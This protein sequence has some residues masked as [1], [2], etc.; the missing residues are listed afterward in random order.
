[1]SGKIK[2]P[3]YSQR[4][5]YD[6]GIEY[7]NFSSNLV[8]NQTIST[9]NAATFTSGNFNITTNID[10][11]ISKFFNLKKYSKYSNLNDLNL[12]VEGIEVNKFKFNL[13]LDKKKLKNY[14]YFGSLKEFLRVSLEKIIIN[15]PAGLKI[16][17]FDYNNP[18]LDYNTY[19]SKS[20]DEVLDSTTF[21]VLKKSIVNPYRVKINPLNT[22][23]TSYNDENPLR[24]LT[25][26]YLNYSIVIGDVYYDLI[27]LT[28]SNDLLILTVKGNPFKNIN[29]KTPYFLRP[30]KTEFEKFFN[31][32]NVF[33]GYLL[34]R[35]ITPI[36][37]AKFDVEVIN[38]SGYNILTEKIVTWPITDG[39]N[40]DYNTEEYLEYV[41]ELIVIAETNDSIKSDLMTRFL[42]SDSILEFDTLPVE[43]NGSEVS[44]G[45]KVNC[46]LKIYGRNF[47]E[48]K[49]YIDGISLAHIVT[50]DASDNTPNEVLKNLA[51]IMGWDVLSPGKDNFLSELLP[52]EN[53]FDGLN[54][55]LN[56]IEV[57]NELWRRLI[58]NTPWLWKSKGTRK[59]LEFIFKFLGI[60]DG[61]LVFNEHIYKFEKS[62][63]T[64]LIQK[65]IDNLENS[66]VFRVDELNID[67]NGFPKINPDNE[68]MY[69]QKAGLWFR[70][71]GGV[72][73]NLD[74]SSGNNPH[75]GVYDGGQEFVNQFKNLIPDFKPTTII[76]NEYINNT[77]KLFVNN[78]FGD[79]NIIEGVDVSI[80]NS[81]WLDISGNLNV[82]TSVVEKTPSIVEINDC[83]CVY[84]GF[85]G[86][87]TIKLKKKELVNE[88]LY[89]SYEFQ[90]NGLIMFNFPNNSNSLNISPECC[91][92]L[93]FSSEL[94][95][96]NFYVCRWKVIVIDNCSLYTIKDSNGAYILFTKDGVEI[97]NVPS[98][99]CCPIGSTAEVYG[100]RFKCLKNETP[101]CQPVTNIIATITE[102]C[103]PVTNIV[104]SITDDYVPPV[105]PTCAPVTNITSSI[106][107]DYVPP[108]SSN[109][110]CYGLSFTGNSYSDVCLGNPITTTTE[111]LTITL[112]D[113]NGNPVI[114]TENYTFIV[115]FNEKTCLYPESQI[116][117]EYTVLSGN[118]SVM[119]TYRTNTYVDCGQGNCEPEYT[120]YVGIASKPT[121]L[122]NIV[123]CAPTV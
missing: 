55:G 49:K 118:S 115:S 66:T 36:Y 109:I 110:N 106:V 82:M 35:S 119:G 51:T 23:I 43:I 100:N 25:K 7:R 57:E 20:Y 113:V 104:S 4:V 60:P 30:N 56:K 83:G 107:D 41:K 33:E 11:K 37:T 117:R 65:T 52:E 48:V 64:I 105:E 29:D 88:C 14:S 77:D 54:K 73:S 39:Y 79:Y 93:G 6:N 95:E 40:I 62:L 61:L 112:K 96:E 74:I 50:Y 91:S 19:Y 26:S 31:S 12:S 99:E 16:N 28:N 101:V 70:E 123:N 84:N 3:G 18:L 89:I 120:Q 45:Q 42:V 58:L 24:D 81:S 22:I 63:D 8:G 27:E 67:N 122:P 97:D 17:N 71:T 75:V 85:N 114:A 21:S 46:V 5:S 47:D 102:V 15:W 2:I 121:Q 10:S 69:F 98:A 111:T 90:E 44:D 72:S 80:L 68:N 92:A 1:M 78:D 34:N 13:N 59:G 9:S 103:Q 76:E 87:L 116:G 32:L 108:T 53:Y 94:G 86:A 38:D